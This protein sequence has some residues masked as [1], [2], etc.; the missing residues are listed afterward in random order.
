[1]VEPMRTMSGT[2]F[3]P[4]GRTIESDGKFAIGSL[5]DA[6]AVR[7]RDRWRWT[8]QLCRTQSYRRLLH[9]RAHGHHLVSLKRQF[10]LSTFSLA[11]K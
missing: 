7:L 8:Y 4:D 2:H 10:A 3:M 1:M 9:A 11:A 6:V 5:A